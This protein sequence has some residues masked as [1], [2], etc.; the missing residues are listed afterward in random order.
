MVGGLVRL[1]QDSPADSGGIHTRFLVGVACFA[2]PALY[3]A[4]APGILRRQAS[5]STSSRRAGDT[6]APFVVVR[7]G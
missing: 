3:A 4:R 7:H 6:D 5:I 2:Y 1:P